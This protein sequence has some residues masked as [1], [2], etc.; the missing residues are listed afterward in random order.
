MSGVGVKFRNFEK[1]PSTK[2][3]VKIP[4][5]EPRVNALIT[6]ALIGSTTD[7][8]AKNINSI[9][10]VSRTTNISGAL[11]NKLWMLSCSRAG[12][13]PI[14]RLNP[15]GGVI[16]R[17]STIFL[18]ASLAFEKTVLDHP[19]RLSLGDVGPWGPAT[20]GLPAI[21]GTP[22]PPRSCR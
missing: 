1:C 17:S 20:H 3:Q 6:A 15:L 7:P 16:D 12:T 22:A 13:P 4:I 9:V 18:A 8:N 5:V 19:H 21:P 2:I 11:S 10:V 14:S